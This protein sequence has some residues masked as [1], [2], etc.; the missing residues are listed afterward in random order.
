MQP[1]E[2]L[3]LA[4]LLSGP[5]GPHPQGRHRSAVSRSY[6]CAFLE[7]RER[8]ATVPHVAIPRKNAHDAVWKAL[9]W[10]APP[11]KSAGHLLKDLKRL[12]ERADYDLQPDLDHADV[13]EA[14]R[15]AVDIRRT[16]ES[17]DM[18]RCVDPNRGPPHP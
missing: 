15:M 9:A 7:V 4:Q 10:A 16:L 12:R 6:Y 2:F 11:L 5:D 18:S 1:S 17:A 8:L 13:L 3:A 14:I